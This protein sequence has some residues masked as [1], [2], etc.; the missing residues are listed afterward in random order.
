MFEGKPEAKNSYDLKD[1]ITMIHELESLLKLHTDLQRQFE[2]SSMQSHI[3]C[4][5]ERSFLVI[6]D[7]LSQ[8]LNQM[9]EKG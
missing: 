2:V 3:Q 9:M 8:A 5:I 1:L 4:C 6:S 7:K